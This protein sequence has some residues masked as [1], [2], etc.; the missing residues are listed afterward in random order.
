MRL[1]LL[2]TGRAAKWIEIG[3][4]LA[5]IVLVMLWQGG[6]LSGHKI[7]PGTSPLPGNAD[8]GAAFQVQPLPQPVVYRAVGTV[9]SRTQVDLSPR[10]VARIQ[11]LPVRSGDRV[12]K[13][14]LLAKLDDQDL[15]AGVRQASEHARQAQAA[16]DLAN[17]ELERIRKLL[18]TGAVTR[19]AFDQAESA[20]RQATAAAQAARDAEK[21]AEAVLGY[22][23]IQSPIDGVVAE[24]LADPGDLASPGNIV[25]RLFDPARLMLEVPVREGLV[26]RIKLGEKVPF[27]VDALRTNLVGEVRE[28]VP[29]VDPG[30]RTFLVKVCIGEAPGLLP[31]MFGVLELSLG[32]RPALLVPETSVARVGQLEYVRV[33][34]ADRPRQLLVRTVPAEKGMRE[35]V[36]GLEAGVQILK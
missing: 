10:I 17:T 18:S 14:D 30:S 4:G 5:L 36:S 7:A 21:Q 32:T 20:V 22:A 27:R 25:L 3:I 13:G 26:S 12:V 23:T 11:E 33:R 28:V 19:Q 34:I 9:R 6:A 24:R 2:P 31:G 35:V 29:S 8:A 16:L 15:A 1:R